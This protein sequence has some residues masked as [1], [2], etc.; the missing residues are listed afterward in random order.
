VGLC[1]QECLDL[2]GEVVLLGCVCH[3]AGGEL[4]L[5]KEAC[6]SGGSVDQ[7]GWEE[8]AAQAVEMVV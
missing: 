7:C 3:V 8:A 4:L 5:F 1:G 6:T 2:D